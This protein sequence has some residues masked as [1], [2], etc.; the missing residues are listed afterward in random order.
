MQGFGVFLA[1]RTEEENQLLK[2]KLE[3]LTDEFQNIRFIGLHPQGLALSANDKMAAVVINVTEWN[4]TETASL[5]GLRAAGYRGPV[6]VTAKPSQSPSLRSLRAMDGV[7]FLEK[8][9]ITKDVTGILRKMLHAR[10]VAQR[11]HRRFNTDESAE[12]MPFGKNDAYETRVVNIS[13]GGAYLEFSNPLPL[14]SGDMVRVKVEL[15]D[16]NRTYT[17]PARIVWTGRAIGGS[18]GSGAG[19]QFVGTPDAKK[20]MISSF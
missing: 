2:R 12:V 11:V 9:F 17:V 16:V 3:T 6:L 13:K 7:V 10:S 20:T 1:S 4:R 8:P 19:I 5:L 18:E 15:K 14:R